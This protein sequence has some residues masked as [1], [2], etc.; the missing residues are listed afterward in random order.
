[1]DDI[2]FKYSFA[3][4]HLIPFIIDF[5]LIVTVS[6]LLSRNNIVLIF[7][8]EAITQM[9]GIKSNIFSAFFLQIIIK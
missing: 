1:M 7:Y 2:G 4:K 3:L 5:F 9:R 8:F 6:K